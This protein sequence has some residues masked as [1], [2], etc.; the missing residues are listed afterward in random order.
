MEMTEM[1]K[2]Y[3]MPELLVLVPVLYILG[4]FIKTSEHIKDKCIP[5]TLGIVGVLLSFLYVV[6]CEGMNTMSVFTA[7]TQG[8][9]VAGG[10]VFINQVVKQGSKDE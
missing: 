3:I 1:I 9:L 8:L 2:T 10:A 6:A 5:H 4:S 7:V